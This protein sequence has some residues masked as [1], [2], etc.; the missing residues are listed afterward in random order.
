MRLDGLAVDSE[1]ALPAQC[2][3]RPAGPDGVD[4]AVLAAAHGGC[5]DAG[6]FHCPRATNADSA[7]GERDRSGCGGDGS[8]P[9]ATDDPRV[10]FD[11]PLGLALMAVG[12]RP[13]QFEQAAAE[14]TGSLPVSSTLTGQTIDGLVTGDLNAADVHG[15]QR[16]LAD[17]SIV[18]SSAPSTPTNPVYWPRK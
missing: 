7:R 1:G 17:T 6:N 5:C 10:P 9:L 2:A 11:T 15:D 3:C 18:Q 14:G 12:A 16:A 4:R 8:G 13:R